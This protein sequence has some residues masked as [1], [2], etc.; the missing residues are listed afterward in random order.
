MR[1]ERSFDVFYASF[2]PRLVRHLY[3]ATGDLERAQD[4]AQE[5]FLRAW[6][7]WD[8]VGA[9]TADPVAWVRTVAWRLAVN[10]WRRSVAHLR[11]LARHGAPPD[12]PSLSPDAVA[13]RTA[14]ARLPREQQVTLVL[15]HVAGLPVREVAQVL[16]VA[17]GTVKA[18]LS[19][20][21]AALAPMLRDDEEVPWTTT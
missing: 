11:A 21:R 10:D 18:R 20:A 9:E 12:T 2:A 5:A 4:C 3:L 16:D 15:H 6:R 13:V 19:R 14:I 1:D 8:T 7:R 17:E